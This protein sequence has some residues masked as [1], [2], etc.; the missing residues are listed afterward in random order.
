MNQEFGFI[1]IATN[2]INGKQYVGQTMRKLKERI[3]GHKCGKKKRVCLLTRAIKKYGI[4]NFKWVSFSCPEEDLDWTE[5][6]LIKELNT[7]TPN[8]YNLE[9]GGNINKHLSED[10]KKKM[11]ENHADFSGENHPQYGKSNPATSERNRKRIGILN[12]NFGKHWSKETTQKMSESKKGK[13]YSLE[14]NKNLS[15]ARI[16]KFCGEKCPTSILKNE[17]VLK[18]KKL[19]NEKELS[20]TK[21]AKIFNISVGNIWKIKVGI[22]WKEVL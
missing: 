11:R 2:L 20:L 1:Y 5:S 9:S 6:F 19:I 18:I 21:I 12:P 10:T 13:K 16:G 7:Q 8:G 3:A 22:I 17:D 4:E 14:H 15:L